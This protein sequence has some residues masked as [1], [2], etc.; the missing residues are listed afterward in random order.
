M[1]FLSWA[2]ILNT[3]HDLWSFLGLLTLIGA[4]FAYRYL[5]EPHSNEPR[6]KTLPSP[7]M[8]RHDEQSENGIDRQRAEK[9]RSVGLRR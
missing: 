6:T 2:A 9:S 5:P 8:E 1:P 4:F 3:V 7:N